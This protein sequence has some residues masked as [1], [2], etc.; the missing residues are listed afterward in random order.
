MT[1]SNDIVLFIVDMLHS[2]AIIGLFFVMFFIL[3]TKT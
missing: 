3:K 1:Y 2:F